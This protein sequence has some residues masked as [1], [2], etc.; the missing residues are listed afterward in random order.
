[1]KTEEQ[2]KQKVEQLF[3]KRLEQRYEKYLNK[4]YRNCLY[5]FPKEINCEEHFF[6]TNANNPDVKKEIIHLC[7]GA[8]TCQKCKYYSC[9]HSKDSIK[10]QMISD[11]SDPSICGV[12]EPKLAVLLWV[13]RDCDNETKNGFISFFKK[14]FFG[15]SK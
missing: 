9:K 12:K 7:E 15:R 10:E 5:N 8:E 3:D 14:L 11:I 6:C 2:I 4:N 13:L 1:M